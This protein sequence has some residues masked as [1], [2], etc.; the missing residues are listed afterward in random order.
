MGLCLKTERLILRNWEGD[1]YLDMYKLY[2]DEKI[3][4]NAGCSVVKNIEK[5]KDNLNLCILKNQS[6]AIVL[7]SENKN[8]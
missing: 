1:N 4:P 7:K 3:N 2:S 8:Q 6:Y 5:I